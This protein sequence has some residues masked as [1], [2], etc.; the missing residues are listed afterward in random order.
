[1]LR[2]T[3]QGFRWAAYA[4]CGEMEIHTKFF[5]KN[6]EARDR[7]EELD[8]EKKRYHNSRLYV[9]SKKG[10]SLSTGSSGS[11]SGP[12]TGFW[13]RKGRRVSSPAENLSVFQGES[14]PTEREREREER[15][16]REREE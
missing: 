8:L 13:F 7:L 9:F 16:R 15:E 14:C 3:N 5:W 1:M 2:I 12:V 6:P 10:G 11:A 4:A